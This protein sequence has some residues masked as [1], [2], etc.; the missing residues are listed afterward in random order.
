MQKRV[1][2]GPKARLGWGSVVG[3]Q[4]TTEAAGLQE[5]LQI[6]RMR[7]GVQIWLDSVRGVCGSVERPYRGH[8]GFP[9]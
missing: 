4:P 5:S 8:K 1:V 3:G 9:G 6:G 2:R 7:A